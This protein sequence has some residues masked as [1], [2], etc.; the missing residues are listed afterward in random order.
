MEN[1]NLA[2]WFNTPTSNRT[3]KKM[4]PVVSTFWML[5]I[6]LACLC[7][8]NNLAQAQKKGTVPFTPM[9]TSYAQDPSQHEV[10]E[11]Y[12]SFL[13]VRPLN[14]VIDDLQPQFDITPQ[15]ALQMAVPNTQNSSE[16]GLSS[17][18]AA[19]QL[20]LMFSPSSL[21]STNSPN[22]SQAPPALN[23]P[24]NLPGLPISMN[25]ASEFQAAASLFQQVKLLNQSLKDIP[26][27][28]NFS[29]Y[30][31]TVQITLVPY[32]RNAPYDAYADLGFFCGN[33]NAPTPPSPESETIPLIFPIL[34]SDELE[35]ASDQQSLNQLRSLSLALSAAYH[36]VGAA[37]NFNQLNQNLDTINGQNL[38]SLLTIGKINQNTVAVR[39]GA[40]NQTG[41]TNGVS[42]VP[43]AHTV[44]FLVLAPKEAQ[45]LQM[46][47]ETTLRHTDTGKELL[48]QPSQVLDKVDDEFITNVL[49]EYFF[50]NEDIHALLKGKEENLHDFE[51]VLINDVFDTN[52]TDAFSNFQAEVKKYLYDPSDFNT[53]YCGQ[54]QN[55]NPLSLAYA[56]YSNLDIVDFDSL[57]LDVSKIGGVGN[58]YANDLIP[59][60]H[61]NPQL[62]KTNQTVLYMDDGQS[63]TFTLNAG[64]EISSA[65]SK[66]S[67]E[68]TLTNASG[69]SGITSNILDSD[70]IQLAGSGKSM[71]IVFPSF[72][73]FINGVTNPCDL[74]LYLETNTD[75]LLTNDYARFAMLKKSQNG[76]PPPAWKIVR[77]YGSLMSGSASN[78]MSIVLA[79]N[80]PYATNPPT[81]YYLDV[82]NPLILAYSPTN[83][84]VFDAPTNGLYPLDLKGATNALVTFTFGPLMTGQ[85][86]NFNLLDKDQ[87]N[88]SVMWQQLVFP[89]GST[90]T[91]TQSPSNSKPG[92][93]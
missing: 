59:L 76:E 22:S 68:L 47:S 54:L 60:T 11:V 1:L 32:K 57:W 14:E 50:P 79:P 19:F 36:N 83:R 61:W 88:V 65:A 82:E 93:Q 27:F 89:P 17:F 44:A 70:Q 38:N 53:N 28:A 49:A 9:D 5:I 26:R 16:S 52:S 69:T 67:A 3:Q 39:L 64:K 91:S 4:K 33:N 63:T 86:V 21:P 92:G 34:T 78:Q 90:Q 71:S 72:S 23:N 77:A 80:Y 13:G 40:R 25:P 51:S 45:E 62:P 84:G 18:S 24:T 8:V 7:L 15:S 74:K 42:M 29:P 81:P 31:I 2:R 85:T 48:R 58:E 46:V 55:N 73:A 43:E 30:I 10:G 87:K 75:E 56:N 6:L 12:V 41:L 66:M 20:G 37:A 35:A